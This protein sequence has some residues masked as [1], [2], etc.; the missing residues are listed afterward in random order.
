M[1]YHDDEDDERTAEQIAQD[2]RDKERLRD[3]FPGVDLNE[4]NTLP[5]GGTKKQ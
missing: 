3:E 5:V 1:S 2:D 4:F